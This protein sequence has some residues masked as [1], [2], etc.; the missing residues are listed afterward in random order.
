MMNPN[1]AEP[2]DLFECIRKMSIYSTWFIPDEPDMSQSMFNAKLMYAEAGVNHRC[3]RLRS[4]DGNILV[5]L[6][7]TRGYIG[8]FLLGEEV[9]WV[10]IESVDEVWRP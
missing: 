10:N 2:G 1:K 7:E 4:F 3:K 8:K 6:G 5:F 9:G